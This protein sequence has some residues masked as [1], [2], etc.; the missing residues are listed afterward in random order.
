M[1]E[2]WRT[3]LEAEFTN[4]YL[5][6]VLYPP[7]AFIQYGSSGLLVNPFIRQAEDIY[8][9][10]RLTPL[11][12]VKAVIGQAR[13]SYFAF[14]CSNSPLIPRQDPYHDVGQAHGQSST[15][16]PSTFEVERLV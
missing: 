13:P 7:C 9:W 2:S 5:R 10:S 4:P 1:G 8:T 12:A 3:V 16:T 6:K 15:P 14:H 11:D